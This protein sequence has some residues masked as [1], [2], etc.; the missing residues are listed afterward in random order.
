MLRR[1]TRAQ[2]RNAVRDVFGVEVNIADLDADSWN[3]NFAVIGAATVVS[4]ERGVEQYQTAIET[5]VNAVFADATKRSQFIGCTPSGARPTPACAVT[6]RRWGC[7]PGAARWRRP[8]STDLMG[9]AVK[10]STELGA[11]VEG[12]RWATVA[13]FISPNFLYRPELGATTAQRIAPPHQLRDRVAP[14][15]SWC[16]AACPTRCCSTRPRTGCWT[17][18]TGFEPR[19]RVCSTRP[20]GAR[21][22]GP[23]PRST[24]ASI[25][26]ARRRKTRR[27]I[28]STAPR[29]RPRWC[30]TCA[31]PGRRS[32]STIERASLD[33]FTTTK[34]V[35]NATSP[36]STAS[37]RPVSPRR[38]SRCGRCPRTARASGILG[39]AGFLSQF[40]NQKEGSPTL[41][42][43]FIREA[44][45][46]TPIPL[47]PG[48]IDIV[49]EDPPADMPLTKRQRLELHRTETS[50]REL[51]PA[52]GP[53]R[54]AARDLR[55]DRPL[56]HDRP[57]PADRPERRLRRAAGRRRARARPGRRRRAWPSHGASSAS[58]TPTRRATKSAAWTTAC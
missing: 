32:R 31:A 6:C 24:C 8:S 46:C 17:P 41:R 34:V 49:L 54:A 5:A 53:A 48:D 56:P 1:L 19:R 44:L 14:R 28:R 47:P 42:G 58:T 21:P 4:S 2:F 22:S 55:R 35:V 11:A 37:T 27:S 23:S 13:L 12:A 3:G 38:P 10:A 25:A 52:H 16:G 15:R 29:C 40:A 30:A 50:V 45:L 20:Q 18:R 43:K 57:R 51:S 9:V 33:L 36:G 26:S 7:A 39:K